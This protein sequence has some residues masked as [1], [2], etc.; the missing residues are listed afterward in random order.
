MPKL[1]DKNEFISAAREVLGDDTV[2]I[3]R[4]EI[5][6]ITK[7]KNIGFPN[8]LTTNKAFRG[9]R[10]TSCGKRPPCLERH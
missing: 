1:I 2:I 3:T 8:W 5:L 6:R 9:D 10:G 7:E 4:Q